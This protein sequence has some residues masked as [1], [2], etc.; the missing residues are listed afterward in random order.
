MEF[1]YEH[2]SRITQI[3]FVP[4]DT[5]SIKGNFRTLLCPHSK[6]LMSAVTYKMGI[7]FTHVLPST[8]N[9]L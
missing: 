5:V 8:T 3:L 1:I 7:K 4:K 6:C 9:I 2:Y